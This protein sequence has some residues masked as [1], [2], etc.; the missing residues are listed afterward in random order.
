MEKYA[1]IC[2]YKYCYGCHSCETACRLEKG[3]PAEE[4][5]IKITEFG[6]EEMS[7]VKS[8][9]FAP[10][11]SHLCDMC[12]DRIAQGKRPKCVHHCLAKC[13]E[14]V[15]VSQISEAMAKYGDQVMCLIP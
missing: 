15:P 4:W 12:E 2:D 10:M 14:A 7:G 11:L 1:L 3:F 5:G 9:N 13:L 6:P 8:W